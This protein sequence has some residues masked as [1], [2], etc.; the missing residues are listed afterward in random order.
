MALKKTLETQYGANAEYWKISKI[1]VAFGA[2]TEVV[3]TGYTS[4][5]AREQHKSPIAAELFSFLPPLLST[6]LE[7]T[8][9]VLYNMIKTVP[10]I[11]GEANPFLTAEDV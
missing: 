9:P 6:D 11:R 3:L 10:T 7:H 2:V 5:S 1:T 8:R 4:Q